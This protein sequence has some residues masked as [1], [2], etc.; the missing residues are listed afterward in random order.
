[1]TR[2]EQ[3][4]AKARE[5]PL[6]RVFLPAPA[7]PEAVA[8]VEQQLSVPLPPDIKELLLLSNGLGVVRPTSLFLASV[9]D[10]R[11]YAVDGLYQADFPGALAIGDDGAVGTYLIDRMGVLAPAG[12]VLLTD[13]GS[14]LPRDTVR[15]G[16]SVLDVLEAVLSGEDLWERPRLNA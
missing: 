13:R 5:E 15:A 12:D 8:E 1:M 16:R 3:L 4:V 7:S 2:A 6:G 9:D 10:I 14:L 11:R